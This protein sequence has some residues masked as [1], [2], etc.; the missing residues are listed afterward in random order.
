MAPKDQLW[1]QH[2]SLLSELVQGY[3]EQ[4]IPNGQ[5]PYQRVRRQAENQK[6]EPETE[7][8][9]SKELSENSSTEAPEAGK[10][11]IEHR[12]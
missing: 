9:S 10:L 8:E 4:A 6:E 12:E 7:V 1:K 5:I 2:G 11:F 3:R